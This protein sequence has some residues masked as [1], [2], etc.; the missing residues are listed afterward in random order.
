[1]RAYRGYVKTARTV[2]ADPS[3]SVEQFLLKQVPAE[4]D[5]L[6]RRIASE[7]AGAK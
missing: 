6:C 1:V 4:Y 3:F 5:A 7:L 2:F